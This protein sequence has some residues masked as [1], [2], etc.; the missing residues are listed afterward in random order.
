MSFPCT[1]NFV[2]PYAMEF[3]KQRSF[4]LLLTIIQGIIIFISNLRLLIVKFNLF[5][6]FRDLENNEYQCT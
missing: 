2:L 3:S 1:V 5:H 6:R 4:S